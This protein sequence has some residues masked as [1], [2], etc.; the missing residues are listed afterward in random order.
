MA[1]VT[2]GNGGLGLET[3]TAL[4]A[5]RAHVIMAARSRA[6]A[7]AARDRI[8]AAHPGAEVEIVLLDLAEL[9][10]VERAAGE[11]RTAH[12]TIDLL[13]NNA[14]VMAVPPAATADGFEIHLGVNHLGHWALTA[15]LL[16]AI[17]RTPG[18]RVVTL[19]S[20]AQHFARP[21]TIKGHTP[22]GYGGWRAYDESK[23]ANR[24][25][26][27]GLDRQFRSA[28]LSARALTAHP[29]F[30]NSDLMDRATGA[31]PRGAI[32]FP[33]ARTMGMSAERGAL[34]QLRAATDPRAEGGTMAGP[35]WQIS[36]P[37]VLRRLIRPG[38]DRA[39]RA[40]WEFSRAATGL[41]VDVTRALAGTTA[42]TA[43]GTTAGTATGT[44]VGTA[45]GT[46][47]GTAAGTGAGAR[48]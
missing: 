1:V 31:G 27:Q 48:T 7:V 19:T 40:L 15:H 8:I 22:R 23:L 17:T 36:G 35:R 3:V 2:G 18:A 10:S 39:I 26:A 43:A 34:S 29:G 42:G 20:G 4:A 24:H 6:R 33:M 41:D 9:A 46:T 28:G 5:K 12:T 45:T 44:T 11:I 32:M 37:P 30:A 13:I 21:I 25:F 47:V 14:G 38:A 16:P